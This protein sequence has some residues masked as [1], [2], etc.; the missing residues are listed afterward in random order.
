MVVIVIKISVISISKRSKLIVKLKMLHHI[1]TN[2][3][4]STYIHLFIYLLQSETYFYSKIILCI[5]SIHNLQYSSMTETEINLFNQSEY[6]IWFQ[7]GLMRISK[8]ICIF[9]SSPFPFR[10]SFLFTLKYV[11]LSLLYG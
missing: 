1:L 2:W 7:V 8:A 9:V 5:L 4:A 3:S 6:S 10:I 11:I